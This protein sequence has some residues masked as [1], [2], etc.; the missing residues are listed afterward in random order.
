MEE[1]VNREFVHPGSRGSMGPEIS[2]S[3]AVNLKLL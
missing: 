3:F 2:V 1:V